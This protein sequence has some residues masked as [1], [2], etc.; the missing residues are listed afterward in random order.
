M[1]EM[2]RK[3]G[4]DNLEIFW[5]H[6]RNIIYDLNCATAVDSAAVYQHRCEVVAAGC[7]GDI[8]V[9]D[10]LTDGMPRR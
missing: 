3:T 8:R 4:L 2:K 6:W 7:R 5:V 10:Y 1:V 9:V